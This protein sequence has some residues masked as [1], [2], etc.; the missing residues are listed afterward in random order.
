MAV[1]LYELLDK[2]K[3]IDIHLVSGKSGLPGIVTWVHM[4]ETAEA[5][6][7]LDGG[8]ITFITG[9]GL[10]TDFTLLDLIKDLKKH[11]ATAAVVNLGPFLHEIPDDVID[12]GNKNDF[13]I[14]V[15]PWEVHIAEIIQIFTYTI[16]QSNRTQL[17]LSS[18][19]KN[20][21]FFPEQENL[22]MVSLVQN[23]YRPE[24]SYT[25]TVIYIIENN[26]N[27][28]EKRINDLLFNLNNYLRY[29]QY[30][31]CA[32]LSYSNEIILVNCNCSVIFM[33]ELKKD[34]TSFLSNFLLD[35]E[36]YFI[37][38]GKKTKSIR[39][40]YKSY[41]QA[42]AI[43]H[44]QQKSS[45]NTNLIDYSTI[46]IYKILLAIED[47]DILDEYCECTIQ[48]LIDYDNAYDSD[49]TE[50]LRQYLKYDGSLKQTADEMFVHRNTVNYKI[51][52]ISEIL[53]MNLSKLNSRLQLAIGFMIYDM[54]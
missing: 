52:R 36:H 29:R 2:V 30:D 41:R 6:Y 13:P 34:L 17:E 14:L 50:T 49:L 22:Y 23:G 27:I 10:N 25:V 51:N 53:D 43:Y 38:I 48:K 46:G 5:S 9:I 47:S 18:T 26:L 16:I 37:G 39:C 21:I 1:S 4:V 35:T 15:V 8:E 40:I 19:F 45:F 24:W 7:F 20:A 3:H 33:D 32:V 44:L 42:T 31:K 28:S 12:Y 11:H 54:K